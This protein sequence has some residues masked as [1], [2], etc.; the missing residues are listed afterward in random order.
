NRLSDI[1]AIV[2]LWEMLRGS[3]S[4]VAETTVHVSGWISKRS[5]FRLSQRE[6]QA[7]NQ[8]Y[9]ISIVRER[10][11]DAP[12]NP[13]RDGVL[14]GYRVVATTA[15]KSPPFRLV[16]ADRHGQL[17]TPP[18]SGEVARHRLSLLTRNDRELEFAST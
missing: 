7:Q 16:V 15:E 11:P 5:G 4:L 10:R 2:A 3:Y 13:V 18:P 6:L 17:A 14:V 8:H 12:H 9:R 1:Q